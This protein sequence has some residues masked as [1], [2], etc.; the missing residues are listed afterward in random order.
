M[1]STWETDTKGH[2]IENVE[3]NAIKMKTRYH[4]IV[5]STYIHNN[6]KFTGPHKTFD[7]AAYSQ[8]V[9]HNWLRVYC[10]FGF[11]FMV[12]I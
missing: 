2:R 9:V 10:R 4:R 7:W 6:K 5:H 1:R 3:F 12:Y 8:Q 11:R